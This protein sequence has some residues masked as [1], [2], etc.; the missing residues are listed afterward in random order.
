MLEVLDWVAVVRPDSAKF[1]SEYVS[2]YCTA[3]QFPQISEKATAGV[4]QL[5]VTYFLDG[6]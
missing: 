1:R 2:A 6:L 3:T 4:H 5:T